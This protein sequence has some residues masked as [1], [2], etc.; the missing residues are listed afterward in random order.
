[1]RVDDE[2][3]VTRI[4]GRFTCATCGAVYHDVTRRPAEDGVCDECGGTE[5]K[6]RADDNED[7]LRNR[8]LEYYKKTSPLIG[9]YH[10][11]G[12]LSEVDGL[13]EIDDV[14]RQVET[15]MSR[16]RQGA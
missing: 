6:R 12:L 10:A 3:L 11:K 9:Y 8:L 13:A 1:M 15:I 4:A 7:A 14:A 2:A 16:A 5:F